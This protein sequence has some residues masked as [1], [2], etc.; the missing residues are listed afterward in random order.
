V[1]AHGLRMRA[2]GREAHLFARGDQPGAEVLADAAGADE[3]DAHRLLLLQRALP[4][5][6]RRA[7]PAQ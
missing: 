7:S 5:E 3:D 4:G 1:L 2:A 6:E